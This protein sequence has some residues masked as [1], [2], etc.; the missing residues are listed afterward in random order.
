MACNSEEG[1]N[2]VA[3]SDTVANADCNYFEV[4]FIFRYGRHSLLNFGSLK[5]MAAPRFELAMIAQQIAAKVAVAR[6]QSSD[7]K[8]LC[9]VL[10]SPTVQL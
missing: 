1:L 6:H 5:W 8:L 9:W 7:R 4:D 2:T 10:L 3:V